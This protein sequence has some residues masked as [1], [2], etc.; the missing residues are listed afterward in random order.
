MRSSSLAKPFREPLADRSGKATKITWSR[1]SSHP[2]FFP[3]HR[4]QTDSIHSRHH[5]EP[6]QCKRS[7]NLS[8]FSC[9]ESTTIYAHKKQ[10]A[11]TAGGM[12][13]QRTTPLPLPA[14]LHTRIKTLRLTHQGTRRYDETSRIGLLAFHQCSFARDQ[15]AF[16]RDTF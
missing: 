5:K 16:L 11:R 2:G 7:R 8:K 14:S 3:R 9:S 1:N 6:R 12:L 15:P 4:F 10:S 13:S